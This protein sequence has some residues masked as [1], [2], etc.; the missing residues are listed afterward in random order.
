[1]KR[2]QYIYAKF[3]RYI[4][5][6]SSGLSTLDHDHAYPRVE[7]EEERPPPDRRAALKVQVPQHEDRRRRRGDQR[8]HERVQ[9]KVAADVGAW[10]RAKVV[11]ETQSAHT[12]NSSTT[13]RRNSSGLS[14]RIEAI[15]APILA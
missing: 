15:G 3:I 14:T 10:S 4:C 2:N 1:M 5:G 11:E 9:A 6:N 8:A 7:V 12:R 13:Y